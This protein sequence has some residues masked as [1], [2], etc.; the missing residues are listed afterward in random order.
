[1][2]RLSR[3]LAEQRPLS[4]PAT[5]LHNDF[6]LDN[7]MFDAQDPGR[8]VAVLDWEMATVGDP[9]V[10]LGI[11]LCYWPE[12]GDP[13]VRREA[14]SPLTTEPG[15]F[16]RQQLLERYQIPH[17]A[18]TSAPFVTTKFSEYSSSPWCCNRSTIAISSARPAM[19]AFAISTRACAA[20]PKP[21]CW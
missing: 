15:W 4:P 7:V 11:V 9:L 14:I 17:R 5:L 3:W 12:P 20:S 6:K 1:M 21:P 13:R 10:D 18:S 8:V 2:K 19:S 16:S